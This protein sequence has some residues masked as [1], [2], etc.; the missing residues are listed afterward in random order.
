MESYS[1]MKEAA[2]ED[3]R[4]SALRDLE[5]MC[6]RVVDKIGRRIERWKFRHDEGLDVKAI[7][8]FFV[9]QRDFYQEMVDYLQDERKRNDTI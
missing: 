8:N 2:F 4:E 5:E 7:L 1:D 3:G 9:I 6:Q